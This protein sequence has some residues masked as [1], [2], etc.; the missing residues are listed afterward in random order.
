MIFLLINWEILPVKGKSTCDAAALPGTIR[1]I[2]IC[3]T[4]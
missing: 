3:R 2:P 4:G 1:S